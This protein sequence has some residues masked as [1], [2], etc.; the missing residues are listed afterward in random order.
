MFRTSLILLGCCFL[1]SS[2][3]AGDKVENPVAVQGKPYENSHFLVVDSVLLHYRTWNDTL[4]H[5]KGK[6][7]LIHGFTGSTFCWRKNVESLTREGYLV[8]AVDLPS[9]G[10]SERNPDLNQSNSNRALLVWKL[11]SKIDQDD[12]AHWDIAGHSMG[13]GIAEAMAIIYPGRTRSLTIVDGMVFRKSSNLTYTAAVAGNN[14]LI[15]R[16][17]VKM[18]EN[19]ILTY[20]T[21][22]RLLKSAYGRPPDSSEVLGYLQPLLADGTAKAMFGV[23]THAK[24]VVKMDSDSLQNTP[25]LIVWGSRDKWIGKGTGRRFHKSLPLSNMEL[26]PGGGHIPMETHPAA[27]DRIF[28]RFLNTR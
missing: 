17:M 25:V 22:R 8:V 5:P 3:H 11:L 16:L 18:A 4:L 7:V 21:M 19:N 20:N 12:P 9:F 13:G 6:I 26:I 15:N 2:V 27:F 1:I 10:Y 24:E 14:R 23:W 28:A